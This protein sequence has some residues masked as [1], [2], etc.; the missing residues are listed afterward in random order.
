MSH[1]APHGSH[2][3][4]RER[5]VSTDQKLRFVEGD[6]LILLKEDALPQEVPTFIHTPPIRSFKNYEEDCRKKFQVSPLTDYYTKF[7]LCTY[8]GSHPLGHRYELTSVDEAW[9]DEFLADEKNA[10]KFTLT[11]ADLEELIDTLEKASIQLDVET[12]DPLKQITQQ[13][14]YAIA[15]EKK[16]TE[17]AMLEGVYAYWKKRRKKLKNPLMREY[18]MPVFPQFPAF[19]V[20]TEASRRVSY[21]KPRGDASASLAK[22]QILQRDF[23]ELKDM[24]GKLSLRE[25]LKRDVLLLGTHAFDEALAE[26]AT[27]RP[28][29]ET[30]AR[31]AAE[32]EKHIALQ[33]A[34]LQKQVP[35]PPREAPLQTPNAVLTFALPKRT[36]KPTKEEDEEEDEDS[37]SDE[38]EDEEV[39]DGE[40]RAKDDTEPD[41]VL[42]PAPVVVVE[43]PP[44]G[45]MV[46]HNLPVDVAAEYGSL[47]LS[48]LPA[49]IYPKEAKRQR[50]QNSEAIEPTEP[51]AVQKEVRER[52]KPVEPVPLPSTLSDVDLDIATED[53]EDVAFFN[54]VARVKRCSQRRPRPPF[55]GGKQTSETLD[56]LYPEDD[57]SEDLGDAPPRSPS[58]DHAGTSPVAGA[59]LWPGSRDALGLVAVSTPPPPGNDEDRVGAL[60]PLPSLD[61]RVKGIC[62]VRE[63]RGGRLVVDIWPHKRLCTRAREPRPDPPVADSFEPHLEQLSARRD[64]DPLLWP[65]SV[66]LVTDQ[67]LS[68]FHPREPVSPTPS[69]P[70][71]SRSLQYDADRTA[72]LGH[73][74]GLGH[75]F[76]FPGN[77]TGYASPAVGFSHLPY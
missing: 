17:K 53:S 14:F 15:A 56:S 7:L 1:H 37:E 24:L 33:H 43:P 68:Q 26:T 55:A 32:K 50:R 12:E 10:G 67:L 70:Y 45:L 3:R 75:A 65:T 13:Q 8:P 31:V 28:W 51:P 72:G 62:R 71:P 47:L 44:A 9:L 77:A 36:A 39:S 58:P 40:P 52:A 20:R 4:L 22:L 42:T 2:S 19:R 11:G 60:C 27:L 23:E 18:H 29:A 74:S 35:P 57:D 69:L 30:L 49:V 59:L 73:L 34:W 76:G 63:A 38:E 21:R 6:K 61:R 64:A 16:F 5:E 66:E 54:H 25:H 46:W 41:P 48:T